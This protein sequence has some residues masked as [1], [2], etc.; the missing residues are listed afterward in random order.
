MELLTVGLRRRLL[1]EL[2]HLLR[3]LLIRLLLELLLSRLGSDHSDLLRL[4]GRVASM[5]LQLLLDTLV[6]GGLVQSGRLLLLLQLVWSRLEACMRLLS[7][8]LLRHEGLSL[9]QVLSLRLRLLGLLGLDRLLLLDACSVG[10]L[11]LLLDVLLLGNDLRLGA[12]RLWLLHGY[13]LRL[14]LLWLLLLGLLGL[15]VLALRDE[16]GAGV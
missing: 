2:S 12:L 16:V 13:T 7:E 11:A 9:S 15:W 1:V 3:L 4:L 14:G 5:L 10:G 8:C 6:E